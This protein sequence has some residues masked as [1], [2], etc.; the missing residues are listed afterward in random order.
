MQLPGMGWFPVPGGS[1]P[2][3]VRALQEQG[4][5][6]NM[7]QPTGCVKYRVSLEAFWRV[8]EPTLNLLIEFKEREENKHQSCVC[9]HGERNPCIGLKG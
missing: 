3:R 6:C 1:P 9:L 4:A 2:A 8:P 7:E 5:H